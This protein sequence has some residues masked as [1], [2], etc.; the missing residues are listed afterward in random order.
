MSNFAGLD[1]QKLIWW[2]IGI[3]QLIWR[4]LWLKINICKF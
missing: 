4:K 2:K 3:T 1:E